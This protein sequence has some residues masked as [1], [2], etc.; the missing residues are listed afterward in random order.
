[1][2]IAGAAFTRRGAELARR[3]GSA[4]CE[5]GD[6]FALWCPS[7][8]AR[9]VGANEMGDLTSWC[10]QEF[11]RSD[12]LLFVGACGIATRA[13][14][15]QVYDKFTDPAVVCIDER[16][17]FAIPL[18]SGHVG[19][20]NELAQR[21]AAATG[22]VA[23][24]TTA[25]DVNGVFAV[26]VLAR[27]HDLAILD[28]DVAKEI[29][30]ALLRGEQVGCVA[31][32]NLPA[33]MAEGIVCGDEALACRWGISVSLD[34]EV[35]PFERTLR[36][37]P[38]TVVVGV[39]CKR[40]TDAARIQA[41]VESCLVQAHVAPEAVCAVATIDV[42]ADEEGLL[43]FARSRGVPLWC[44]SAAELAAVPGEFAVSEFV[45]KTVGVGNVCER[46]A[47]A[48]GADLMLPRQSRDGVTVALGRFVRSRAARRRP[49]HAAHVV[50][51]VGI[52][53]GGADDMTVRARRA[54]ASAEVIVGYT[55][56]VNLVRDAFPQAEFVTT[57]MRGEERRCRMALE[58]AA[59]GKRVAVVCSGDAGVYGMAGLLIELAGDY[60]SVEIEVVPGVTAANGGAAV[61]GAPLMHDWCCISLSDLMTPWEVIEARL[62]AAAASGL[63]IVLYNPASHGRAEHLQRACDV[64]LEHLE[65]NTQCGLVRNIGR[66]GQTSATLSLGELRDTHVD[67]LTCVFVGNE[68]TRLVGGRM[69]TPRGYEATDPNPNDGSIRTAAVQRRRAQTDLVPAELRAASLA[70]PPSLTHPQDQAMDASCVTPPGRSV[71]VFGGTTEGRIIAEWLSTRG[72]CEVLYCTAT[73]YGASLV[74]G[75]RVTTIQGPLS[76]EEKDRLLAEHDVACIVD[77]THPYAE[78]I[79]ASIDELARDHG[80]DVVRVARADST[81][82]AM[83]GD[84]PLYTSVA[85][86][87]EA[88]QLVAAVPGNVLLTTGTN[89]LA[90]FIA[91]MDD[92][93]ERLYVRIL[94]VGS[95]L[96]KVEE[97]GIPASHIV[98]MQGPFSAQLNCA[99][100]RALG[101]AA[102]VT[103]RSGRAGG[104]DE[105]VEAARECG[106]RL[107][108][109]G[110]PAGAE[111]VSL[112]EAQRLLEVNY[113]L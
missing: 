102:V 3:I 50:T 85:N 48:K 101:I 25:T 76:R 61:L 10:A 94:P 38:R 18:L 108:V 83:L 51:C 112:D 20:A 74:A 46:A 75:P 109:I 22:G 69:V 12:A 110:R 60:G 30:A 11:A 62:R 1:M 96:A 82:D 29:S 27:E 14:A 32:A 42:K 88:A 39:G 19:G 72:S 111:G 84:G 80:K 106:T 5:Q 100:I 49:D 59:S 8:L 33:P 91:V 9:E 45:Q 58:R 107:V 21:V 6:E 13:I 87:Q 63:V 23:A 113:G 26:D 35:R 105:K 104:F 98:A 79:S 89:E 99:L 41:L 37:A 34:P 73:E 93:R 92:Y 17:S 66:E 47:C 67:M 68:Q 16:G 81:C 64:L 78:H 95:S 7:R 28:R 54:L 65:P 57:G 53:P 24:I 4:L 77:A 44:Y 43:A 86:T 52:G 40:G 15:P 56:Y 71:L 103:K 31:D 2:R 97:L 90:S 55:T 36:L 70:P